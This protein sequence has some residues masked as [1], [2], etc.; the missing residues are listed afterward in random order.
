M[1]PRTPLALLAIRALL[2]HGQLVTHQDPQSFSTELLSSRLR[3]MP[4]LENVNPSGESG[5]LQAIE[6]RTGR[7]K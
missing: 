2:A 3:Q 4:G 1:Y 5:K 6:T 7:D